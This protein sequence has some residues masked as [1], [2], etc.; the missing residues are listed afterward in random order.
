MTHTQK[1]T[2]RRHGITSARL[3]GCVSIALGWLAS[4]GMTGSPA[5]AITIDEIPNPRTEASWVADAADRLSPAAER[6]LNAQL[7]AFTRE[8]GMELAVVTVPEIEPFASP[9]QLAAELRDRWEI[10]QGEKDQGILLLVSADGQAAVDLG[11]SISF[12]PSDREIEELLAI[13]V[14]PAIDRDRDDRA[15][16][17]GVD[18]LIEAVTLSPT[19]LFLLDGWVKVGTVFVIA[20]VVRNLVLARRS[21]TGEDVKLQ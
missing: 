4:F 15:A 18:A 10:G 3:A 21:K 17:A 20:I 1:L 2:A 11:S 5:R 19:S 12:P 6:Q 8:R 7:D 16:I 9:K 13:H 14:L